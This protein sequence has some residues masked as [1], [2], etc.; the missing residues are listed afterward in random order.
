M[1]ALQSGARMSGFTEDLRRMCRNPLC[2]MKLP[3]PTAN[4]REAFCTRGCHTSF[5]RKRCIV[6]EKDMPRNSKSQLTCYRKECRTAW[7]KK[8]IFSR[9]LYL[10]MFRP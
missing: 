7:R 10:S 8:A 5:Y 1:R 6:C 2:R 4:L 3:E 9:F